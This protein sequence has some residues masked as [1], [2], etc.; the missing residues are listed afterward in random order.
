MTPRTA[1]VLAGGLGTRIRVLVSDRSKVVARVGGV[2]FLSFVLDRLADAGCHRA[3]L[4]TGH[5]AESVE[6]HFGEEHAGMSLTYSREETPLGTG[7]ALRRALASTTDETL[8]CVN[9]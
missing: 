7:G 5:L 9:G 2:P 3:V 8:L 6:S 1:L 4:C